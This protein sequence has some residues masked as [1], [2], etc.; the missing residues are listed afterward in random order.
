MLRV[1]AHV[2]PMTLTYPTQWYGL[3]DE[4]IDLLPLISRASVE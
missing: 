3:L 4:V 1:F 2:D